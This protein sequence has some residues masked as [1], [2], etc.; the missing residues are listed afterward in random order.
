V[1]VDTGPQ[2]NLLN[3]NVLNYVNDVFVPIDPGFWSIMGVRHLEELI[4]QIKE[5]MGHTELRIGGVL[6][7]KVQRTNVAKEVEQEVREYFGGLVFKASIPLNVKVEEAHSRGL[8]VVDYDPE[9]AGAQA[10]LALTQ[11]IITHDREE[12]RIGELVAPQTNKSS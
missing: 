1:I 11:E 7:T 2:R 4:A 9:S 3:V 6:M 12:D 5:H 8:A 10:Y